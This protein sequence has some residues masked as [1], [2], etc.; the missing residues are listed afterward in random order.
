MLTDLV[1]LRTAWRHGCGALLALA[2]A[3]SALADGGFTGVGGLVFSRWSGA[4]VT[5]AD[6]RALVISDSSVE[7]YDPATRMFSFGG[8][9]VYNH[10]SGLTATLLTDG[11]VLIVGG[12]AFDQSTAKAEVFDP[13]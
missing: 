9:L 8:W 4:S 10:G 3:S 12:Q 6:G 2:L 1:C 5:T 13:V 7:R 11:R